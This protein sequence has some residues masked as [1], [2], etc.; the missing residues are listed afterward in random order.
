MTSKIRIVIADDERPAREFLKSLLA[1]FD[2][3]ENVG[4]A[5]DGVE[6]VQLIKRHRPDM[7]LLD[8][9]MPGLGGLDVVRELRG[10]ELPHIA[11][12]TAFDNFAVH[13]FELNAIDYLLKPVERSRL[14]LTIDRVAR[15]LELEDSGQGSEIRVRAASETYRAMTTS[16]ILERIP[17]KQREDIVFVPVGEIASIVADGELLH[18]TTAENERYVIN[19]RLKD[20]ESRLDRAKFIRLSRGAIVSLDMIDR[21]SPMPGGTF[22]VNM[23]NGQEL[24]TS[25]LQSR[26]IRSELL[27]L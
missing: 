8:L 20:L 16:T 7:A 26:V 25:R 18:I 3:V 12:V 11:F 5:A 15:Q 27:K 2:D 14:R 6:A 23:K 21:V 19:F 22:V 9:Q 24:A 4:E 17:V 10:S 1:G 13:A